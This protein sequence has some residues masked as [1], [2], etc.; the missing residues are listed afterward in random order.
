M[1]DWRSEQLFGIAVAVMIGLVVAALVALLALVRAAMPASGTLPGRLR[2]AVCTRPWLSGLLALVSVSCTVVIVLGFIVGGPGDGGVGSEPDPEDE[3]TATTTSAATLE[4]A[5]WGPARDVASVENRPASAMLNSVIDHPTYGDE[6]N[7]MRIAASDA[8][9]RSFT[10]SVVVTPG[11][12][13]TVLVAIH[14]GAREG[15]ESAEDVRLR[16]QFPARA[17]GSARGDALVTAS[18]LDPAEIWDG[19]TLIAE[20]PG[21]GFAIRYVPSS[22]VLHTEGEADGMALSEEIFGDG[23]LLGCDALDGL[24]PAGERCE[25]YV[26]LEIHIDQPD[27]AVQALA[28]QGESDAWSATRVVRPGERVTIRVSY[29]NTGTVQQS[30]VILTVDLPDNV[31]YVRGSTRWTNST[32]DGFV[33][34]VELDGPGLNIGSYAPQGEAVAEFEV[35]VAGPPDEAADVQVIEGF[36]SASTDNGRKSAAL[37]LVWLVG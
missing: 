5:G 30:N 28:Q 21:A 3:P 24:L 18:N 7:F 12:R 4:R 10:D 2:V 32:T 31:R 37:T 25:A 6:R 34:T 22:A 14:N 36:V 33:D 19:V 1:V 26:T 23:V 11:G 16:L 20:D 17:T 13:Y 27:F 35:L 8:E 15:G 29:Q 9:N